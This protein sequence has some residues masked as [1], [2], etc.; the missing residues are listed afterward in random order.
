[1]MGASDRDTE[2]RDDE[3]PS[4]KVTLTKDFLMGKYPVTQE[5]W[6]SV[7]GSNPSRF[8]GAKTTSGLI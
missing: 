6:E 3:K 7:M 4:H 5:L 1:M 8:K 2:A